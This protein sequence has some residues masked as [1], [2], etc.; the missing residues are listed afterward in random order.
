MAAARSPV[1]QHLG[2]LVG[3]LAAE[4]QHRGW[5]RMHLH[6]CGLETKPSSVGA[7]VHTQSGF[8]ELSRMLFALGPKHPIDPATRSKTA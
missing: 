2:L 6:L 7:F 3:R 1:R 8:V 4:S 5:I